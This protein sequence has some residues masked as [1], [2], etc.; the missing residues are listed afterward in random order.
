MIAASVL[1]RHS[2]VWLVPLVA[3]AFFFN[4]GAAPLFDVDEG[5]FSAATWEM[6]H[7]GEY[8][9]TYLNGD[10]R[11]DKPI[12]IYWLQAVSVSVF[13]IT[14]WSFRLPSALAA[15]LWVIAVHQFTVSRLGS[16]CAA[17]AVAITATTLTVV[18]IGRAATADALLNLLLTLTLFDIYR[19]AERPAP[20]P[21]L[22]AYLWMALGVITKGPVAVVI[23]LVVSVVYFVSRGRFG[24][25]RRAAFNLSGWVIFL[26]VASPWYL[27][28]YL[29]QG[30]AFID[31]FI[32]KHNVG[33]FTDTMEG[34][35]GTIFYYLLMIVPVLMPY[36]GIFLVLLPRVRSL[37]RDPLDRWLVLWFVVVFVLF[38]FSNTQL[39]HYVL[40]GCTPLFVLMARHRDALSSRALAFVPVAILLL[41]YLVLPQVRE[42]LE[43]IDANGLIEARP[44]EY[45]R[46]VMDRAAEQLGWWYRIVPGALLLLVGYLWLR[47]KAVL[48]AE[49]V[50]I[51]ILHLLYLVAVVTPAI[52]ETLQGPVKAA[53][54]LSRALG[55]PVVTWRIDA[56]SFTVYRQ[57]VTPKREPRIG[58]LVLSRVGKLK[59]REDFE[60]LSESGG[61]VLGKRIHNAVD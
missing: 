31:G 11:F 6:L 20:P 48:H 32:L 61:I 44:S 22:R 56:P 53:G 16:V 8:V 17:Y 1:L 51:G 23:P 25:W 28:E 26:G 55:E 45:D 29:D 49:L 50:G 30:Q 27:L 4:L 36:G 34:H 57:A 5:A 21:L 40:Y 7:R 18:V 41:L 43:W 9:T 39:P 12:L 58:E 10:P 60:V 52:G 35:G 37:W 38:S 33:R 42:L 19:Y 47:R 24:D 59:P 46:A 15:S 54:L 3:L 2:W 14:E 13:G